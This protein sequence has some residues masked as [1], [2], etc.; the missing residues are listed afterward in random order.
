MRQAASKK[1]L[2]RLPLTKPARRICQG[3]LVVLFSDALQPSQVVDVNPN[4]YALFRG[5]PL[6]LEV[7]TT[8][9]ALNGQAEKGYYYPHG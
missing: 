2:R 7:D 6:F 9:K 1:L 8:K 3:G 5:L 4:R